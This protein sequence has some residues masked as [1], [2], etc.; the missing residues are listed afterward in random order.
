MFLVEFGECRLNGFA[1]G[2]NTGVIKVNLIDRRAARF[3]S[4]TR[5]VMISARN[6]KDGRALA[7]VVPVVQQLTLVG[8]DACRNFGIDAEQEPFVEKETGSDGYALSPASRSGCGLR[9]ALATGSGVRANM[10]HPFSRLRQVEPLVLRNRLTAPF[11]PVRVLNCQRRV[12]IHKWVAKC[13][14]PLK[15]EGPAL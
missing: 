6:G 15:N 14:R 3:G 7:V 9:L 5:E 10:L 13:V 8:L 1:D 11:I 12:F 4:G 2:F